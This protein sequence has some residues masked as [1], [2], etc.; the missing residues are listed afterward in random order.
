MFEN[1]S[2]LKELLAGGFFGSL[3]RLLLKPENG[4]KQWL[5][6]FVV[7][8]SAA[9]FLGGM[10]GH[11]IGAGPAGYASAAYV[12]GTAAEKTLELFQKKLS[13]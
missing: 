9:V 7:G 2:E 12:I 13:P 1:S 6:Q 11:W 8:I 4:W 3:T 5:S 10:V